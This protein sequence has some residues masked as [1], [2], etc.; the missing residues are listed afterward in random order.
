MT[1]QI[2]DGKAIANKIRQEIAL[3]VTKIK[4]KTGKVPTLAVILVGDDPASH[5]YVRN[6][7]KAANAAMIRSLSFRFQDNVSEDDLI[8]KI[9]ELNADNDVNGILVQLPLPAHIDSRKVIYAI[10]PNKDVD[11]FNIVNVG[12]LSVGDVDGDGGAIVPCTPLGCI[13]L[14]KIALGNDLSG[15]KA[16]VIGS[17]NI[18]GRPLARLLM[19]EGCTVTIANRSTKDLAAEVRQADIVIPATGVVNLVKKDMV[20]KGAVVI[21]VG[22]NRVTDENGV[23]FLVGDVD[24]ESVKEVAKAIT[25]VPGG[26]GPMTIAYLLKNTL[27]CFNKMN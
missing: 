15:L 11:G 7:E 25:P 12:K 23:D 27:K 26:V 13:H 9:K 8:I 6:K 17:S 10:D 21:D 3:E 24:F 5:V 18:V 19:L 22:I 20:K 14:T 16:L 1:A 2:I 4:E